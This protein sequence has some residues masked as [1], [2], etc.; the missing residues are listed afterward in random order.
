MTFTCRFRAIH[1]R[2]YGYRIHWD[3]IK[4]HALTSAHLGLMPNTRVAMPGPH[5]AIS[6]RDQAPGLDILDPKI[7]QRLERRQSVFGNVTSLALLPGMVA[8]APTRAPARRRR[9]TDGV[10]RGVLPVPIAAAAAAGPRTFAGYAAPADG[11]VRCDA[12]VHRRRQDHRDQWPQDRQAGADDGHVGLERQPQL[13][14]EEAHC[15]L[16][17][18]KVS[19]SSMNERLMQLRPFLMREWVSGSLLRVKSKFPSPAVTSRR[20]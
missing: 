10:E 2:L 4:R 15:C 8:L 11:E 1:N 3:L 9:P 5:A 7:L 19:H 6:L 12:A 13:R 18:Y 14:L 16:I 20:W 17:V